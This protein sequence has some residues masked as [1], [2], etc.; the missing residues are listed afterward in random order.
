MQFAIGAEVDAELVVDDESGGV[1]VDVMVEEEDDML[2]DWLDERV[3]DD[4][5]DDV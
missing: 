2:D 3:A 5:I 1:G 4:L